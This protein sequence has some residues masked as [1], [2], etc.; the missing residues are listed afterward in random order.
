[1]TIYPDALDSD[2]EL[3]RAN[4]NVSEITVDYINSLRDAVIALQRT[5]GINPHGQKP[6][7]S[8]RINVSID[9]NGNIKKSSLT[10]IGLVTLPIVDSHV[11]AT[12]GIKEQKLALDYN[13][14][15]LKTM[16]D[17]LRTDL[18]GAINGAAANTNAINKH[19]LG[20]GNNHDGYHIKINN[21]TQIGVAGLQAT[22]VGDAINEISVRLL[23][24]NGSTI[25]PHIDLDISSFMKH[26][27]EKISVDASEFTTIDRA[28][29][30]VQEALDSIDSNAELLGIN[31][32]DVFH[33]N[34]I[35]KEIK[36]GT[37][38]NANRM[39][40]DSTVGAYYSV[41]TSVVTIPG[42]SSFSALGVQLGD[43]LN[44]HDNSNISDAGSY[45]ITAIGPVVESATLG[46][47]PV[48]G[49]NQ[50]TVFHTF[51]ESGLSGDNIYVSIYKPSTES[52]EY[53]PLACIVRNNE[54]IVDTISVLSPDA[55][56][57]VSIG[58]NG[59]IINS[60]GY[61]IHIRVGIDSTQKR[62][63]TIPDLNTVRLGNDYATP[64]TSKSVAEKINAYVSDPDLGN[65][66]PITAYSVGDELI[67]AHNWVG[68]NYTLEILDGYT[69][70]YALGFD[71]YGANITDHVIHGSINNSFCINGFLSNS[72][73]TIFDGYASLT[74]DLDTFVL[75]GSDGQ[76]ANPNSFG[77]RSGSV[78]HVSG[79]SNLDSNGSYTLMDA[80]SSTVS[81]FSAEPIIAPS[82]PTVFNVKFTSADVPLTILNNTETNNGIIDVYVIPGGEIFLHQRFTYESNIGSGIE[83]VDISA[84]FPSGEISILVGLSGDNVSF[85]IIDETMYGDTVNIQDNFRG[86]FKLYHSNGLDYLRVKINSDQIPGGITTAIVND[87]ISYDEA[88]ILCSSHFNG[89]LSITYTVDK[90]IFGN[91]NQQQIGD[92]FIELFSQRPVRELRSDG[93]VRGFD[94]LN[95]LYLDSITNMQSVSVRGGIAYINGSRVAVETQ[96]VIVQSYDS[97]GSMIQNARK[98]IA[99]SE[100]GSIQVVNEQLG[101]LLVDGYNSNASFGKMLPLYYV[102]IVSGGIS[103]IIDIRRFINNIDDKIEIIVDETE[104][105][106]G[107]FRSLEGALL[108]ADKYPDREKL[109]IRII[110]SVHL[111]SAITIPDGISL[112]G[113]SPYGGDGKHQI[114]NNSVQN[115]NLIT[116][117]GNNRVENIEIISPQVA[118][119][120]ALL[121]VDGSNINIEKCLFGFE[122]SIS[123]NN[124][125]NAIEISR[126]CSQNVTIRNNIIDNVYSGIVSEHGVD[127]IIVSENKLTNVSGTGGIAYAIIIGSGFRDVENIN[128][129]NNII[130]IPSI[131]SG[132]DMRGINVSTGLDINT[133]RITGNNILHESQNTM[134]NGI[135][136]DT[137]DG[138]TG[139]INSL[140][141]TD[142]IVDGIKLDDNYVFGI[143]V[144]NANQTIIKN[145]ILTNI[146]VFAQDRT[147][148]SVI[149]IATT[150]GLTDVSGNILKDNDV[151]R[152]IEIEAQE[153][154]SRV[155]ITNNTIINIGK[156]AYYIRG[157]TPSSNISGN[158]IVGP[159][160]IAIKWNGTGTKISNNNI[161]RPN[162][163]IVDDE[164][165]Y[166]FEEYAIYTPSS[167]VDI[168]NN[169]I[170][171]MIFEQDSIGISNSPGNNRLKVLGNTISG[172]FMLK[173]IKLYGSDHVI[174]NNKMS[175][176]VVPTG[177]STLCIELNAVTNSAIMGNSFRGAITNAIT[178]SATAVSDL[179]IVNNSV[180]AND[181]GS[182]SILLN[183]T[184]DT[185]FVAGNRFPDGDLSENSIGAVPSYGV[186]NSNVLGINYGMKDTRSIHASAGITAFKDDSVPH[187][188]FKD[189]G[190]FWEIN[191]NDTTIDRN[192]Y[193]PI[194]G[195]PNGVKLNSVQIQGQFSDSLFNTLEARLYKRSTQES[196]LNETAISALKEI[197]TTGYFGNSTTTGLVS[198]IT[199]GGEI[200]NYAESNYFLR[201]THSGPII[202]YQ[203][204][205]IY[206]I[207]VNF[208]Y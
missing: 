83:I 203:D 172:S 79:H 2:L 98:I 135:R 1:M 202:I 166:A 95:T 92:D 160:K 148:T 81:L 76:L 43:I 22:T 165:D 124:G 82:N 137:F 184:T 149:R 14:A 63:L 55:A 62:E 86:T 171:G 194:N 40:L 13:T 163:L 140:I 45:Q 151:L 154:S 192:L 167:D 53:A 141:I 205:N 24:G 181:I 158:N 105:V 199:S 189:A 88:M 113:G 4:D 49:S 25:D 21:G 94:V 50:L 99:I 36:S 104:G 138:Y 77:I 65:H 33:S 100:Y 114:I 42:V 190:Q 16:V 127:N 74:S 182:G 188:S 164:D 195:L 117:S 48:L 69:A 5:L 145:N 35:L 67:I 58:F 187:W 70:N 191:D 118:L 157:L 97:D 30:T 121:Y 107:N 11:S 26:A 18:N 161:S 10:S 75:W 123:T 101:E 89:S 193:F 147:D 162:T 8:D 108:F 38:Y 207:T 37:Y 60:D 159:G 125:N 153:Q 120:G 156:N 19:F 142:N 28:V 57:A 34:G 180:M 66:F 206:G 17:S 115:D 78:M 54:T 112:I 174:N 150:S 111:E 176:D 32:A 146:G 197:S 144:S 208:T 152:G 130:N 204:I 15:T 198:A 61:D 27:A 116:L 9:S 90:R 20:S 73:K 201:I 200:I 169:T 85:N 52:S 72:L 3:P 93:V 39:L 71:I 80:N 110:N 136:A 44:I 6:S 132:T 170:T 179:T 64:V 173:M 106:I 59:A 84:G 134:T 143:Y 56:K 178:S 47:L 185:C 7:V 196:S 177:Q 155:N 133:V 51:S 131:L 126:N 96:K 87:R 91:I 175:N 168:I 129:E 139:V 29:L 31:H 46:G 183:G 186:Y 41:G 103:G 12:A 68:E 23:S 102:D 119:R 128:I 109:T 122:E